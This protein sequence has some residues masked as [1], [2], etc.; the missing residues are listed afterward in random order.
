MQLVLAGTAFGFKFFHAV[1]YTNIGTHGASRA[2]TGIIS[3]GVAR[4]TWRMFR[5]LPT[6]LLVQRDAAHS[7]C[8]SV[9]VACLVGNHRHR[10]GRP[11]AVPKRRS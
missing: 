6:R 9:T 11:M 2:G 8:G 4:A 7:F 3:L 10:R 1:L 5:R